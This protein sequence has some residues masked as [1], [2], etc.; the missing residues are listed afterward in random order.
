[1]PDDDHVSRY[2]KPSAVQN[3]MVLAAAF[4]VRASEKHLSVNW[5]EYFEAPDMTA[6]VDQVRG[7]F[8]RKGY[9]L[10][11]NGRFA[12]LQVGALQEAAMRAG[13][14]SAVEHLP[15]DD[16]QSHSGVFGYTPDDLAVAVEIAALVRPRHVHDAVLA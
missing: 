7:A 5:L 4:E 8:L 6:A 14:V 10:R 9:R 1:M 16:D 13:T 12:V 2:C 15:E 11:P 3:G